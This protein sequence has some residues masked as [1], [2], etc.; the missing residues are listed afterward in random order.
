[1][2]KVA[3]LK[4]FLTASR[5]ERQEVAIGTITGAEW[6]KQGITVPKLIYGWHKFLCGLLANM[7]E[8][9]F[10][11]AGYPEVCPVLFA[12]PG[13][14]LLVMRRAVM[15]TDEEWAAFD[16][17]AFCETP[18]YVIPAEFK[19]DSFGKLDGRIVAI[20]YGN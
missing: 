8:A 14:W 13:G 17:K 12:L 20:D 6:N 1:M 2:V 9:T 15:L 4:S 10:G 3:P 5:G 16:P 19:Q 7:Q 18:N 11:R